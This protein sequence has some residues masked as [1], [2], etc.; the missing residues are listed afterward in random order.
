MT[1]DRS[2][3]RRRTAFSLALL[4]VVVALPLV[5]Y[6]WGRSSDRFAVKRIVVSGQ[7]RVPERQLVRLLESRYLGE[8]LFTID[9]DDVRETLSVYPYVADVAIDHDYPDTLR[10]RLTEYRPSALLFADGAW[11]VLSAEGRALA[12]L[13]AGG[14]AGTEGPGSSPSAKPSQSPRASPSPTV[15]PSPRP[16]A[17]VSP[18]PS[19]SRLG[20]L[21]APPRAVVPPSMRRLPVMAT[22]EPV[23]VGEDVPDPHV[24]EGLRIAAAL[25]SRLRWGVAAVVV[26]DTSARIYL[27]D[28]LEWEFGDATELEAKM[29]ALDAVLRRYRQRRVRCTFVDVSVPH[30]PL[31]A[32]VLPTAAAP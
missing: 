13:G 14:G 10:V 9:V 16:S 11:Y 25:P 23:T 20:P 29:L 26:T 8:N 31:G 3:R 27:R 24:T 4:A 19:P 22:D 18:S 15:K 32:P 5:V 21:P 12:E 30:R 1:P 6:L 28:G 17:T 7:R 2:G